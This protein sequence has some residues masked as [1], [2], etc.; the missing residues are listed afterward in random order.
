MG[1][2]NANNEDKNMKTCTRI[3]A[4]VLAAAALPAFAAG[5]PE[6]PVRA[7]I[8]F[9]PGSATDIIGRVV[10]QKLTEFWGQTVVAD[11]P[12]GIVAPVMSTLSPSTRP[13]LANVIVSAV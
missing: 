13:W 3:L 5:Y 8:K 1:Y 7:I 6:R 10:A 11:N 9:P 4:A 2:R 12:A